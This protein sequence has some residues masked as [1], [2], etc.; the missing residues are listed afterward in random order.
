MSF[1]NM[2]GV[3]KGY[4]QGSTRVEVLRD[5]NLEIQEGEFVAIVGYSGSGKSTLIQ[6]LSGLSLPDQGSIELDGKRIE[7]PGP[8]RGVVFQNYS[9]LPWLTVLGNVELAVDRVF[10]KYTAAQRREHAMRYISM[11]NLAHAFDRRPAE[12]S[13]GMRQRVSVAR[14]LAMQPRILLLDEPLGAL[15]ALT[16]GKLQDE[17]E[18]IMMAERRTAVLI[19]NDV[20][21]ALRLADRVI[22]LHPGPGAILGPEFRVEL[23][24]PRDRA[25]LNDQAEYRRLRGEINQYL[26]D[27]RRGSGVESKANPLVL[28]DLVPV[29]F[30]RRRGVPHVQT[31]P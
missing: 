12:L 4:G 25:Q 9:L 10:P 26:S 6:L 22:P 15:D 1:L 2:K 30:K 14:A 21:E 11:V 28:P 8:D 17:I 31:V 24:R 18:S 13:G 23:D 16:R 7:G 19:T 3:S 5:I 27:L 29:H 20:D